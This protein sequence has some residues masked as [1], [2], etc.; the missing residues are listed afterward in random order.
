MLNHRDIEAIE[1][2]LFCVLSEK[3][4]KAIK[5]RINKIWVQL[6]DGEDKWK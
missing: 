6:C 1:D 4:E 3:E 2:K 5:K